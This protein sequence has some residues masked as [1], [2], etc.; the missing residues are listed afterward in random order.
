MSWRSFRAAYFAV[1][2]AVNSKVFGERARPRVVGAYALAFVITLGVVNAWLHP[3]HRVRVRDGD[4]KPVALPNQRPTV[5]AA[6]GAWYA[7]AK[8][9]YAKVHGEG[10][11]PMLVVATAGGGIRAAYWTATIL[12]RL[13]ADFKDQGGV[14]PY[15]FAISGVSGGSVGATAF[16][17][18]V[19]KRDEN[20]CMAGK[21]G[22]AAC[23]VAT[24][25]LKED[26][27]AP[28]VASLVLWMRRRVFLPD[29]GQG[30]RGSALEKSFEHASDGL[31]A[32]PFL[33]FFHLAK[34]SVANEG[35][36][37]WRPILLLNATHE[38]SGN[39]IITGQFLSNATSLLTAWTRCMSLERTCGQ[40][41]R[42]TTARVSLTFLQRAIWIQEGLGDRRRI[43]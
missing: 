25:F 12:E 35:Q 22:D 10:P 39:R 2:W 5:G 16:D 29:L 1:D 30:D 27:L 24:D 37:S 41:Q 21:P 34:D 28:A 20:H 13:E 6:A 18:A 36:E 8:S 26:F 32:R 43:F 38:E 15:L 23:P 4:C 42:R 40:A 9:A 17:A 11:V 33:S 14:R 3:F 7:Q 19:I 31:L